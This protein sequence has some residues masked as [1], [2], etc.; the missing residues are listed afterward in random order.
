ME[1]SIPSLNT[2][3]TLKFI[4]NLHEMDMT[5][6][7]NVKFM[8]NPNWIRPLG[9][10][11]CCSAIK[12]FRECNPNIPMEMTIGDNQATDYAGHMGFYQFISEQLE[13]GNAP[14]EARGNENYVPITVIDFDIL[15]R[16]AIESGNFGDLND[17]IENEAKRLS[18]VLCRNDT[19]MH[20]LFSY[21]IRE[22]LRNIPEH[23]CTNKAII[24]AQYW[25]DGYAQIAIMDEGIGIK[26]SLRKNTVHKEYIASDLDA[27]ESSIK[28]GISQSFSPDRKN[29]S[30]DA[31]SNSGFGL[32]MASE[33][34]KRLQGTFWMASGEKAIQ[35]NSH[36]VTSLDTFFEGTAIGIMFKASSL[37][38][39]QGLISEIAKAGEEE[40]K[41]IR[42]AFKHAS[43]PSKSLLMNSKG[44]TQK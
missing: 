31:W 44:M 21:I 2:S 7:S 37:R 28:P 25:R 42:N 18:R 14:G 38:D 17:T 30:S 9:T 40:A 1:I 35:V 29:K 24:C 15:H 39:S 33:I 36:A 22:I 26:N 41:S 20:K 8:F 5:N 6:E 32:Y 10:I 4:K 16:E 11:L 27:L 19:N 23:A 43:E 3:D 12:K 34:C 13:I